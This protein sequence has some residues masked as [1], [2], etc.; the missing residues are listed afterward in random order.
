MFGREDPCSSV[1]VL[2]AEPASRSSLAQ[3]AEQRLRSSPYLAL[4]SVCCDEQDGA[5]ILR[6]SL[7]T[8][9]LKQMAQAIVARVEGVEQVTNQIEVR[10]PIATGA[11]RV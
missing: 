4:R 10:A 8:Y 7:P 9:Y 2:P 5:L 6:G 11:R 3:V 1:A